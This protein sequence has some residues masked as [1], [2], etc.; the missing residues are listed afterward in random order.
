[1]FCDASNRTGAAVAR[2]AV[3]F[4]RYRPGAADDG[5]QVGLAWPMD[6][7]VDNNSCEMVAIIES[8]VVAKRELETVATSYG[9]QYHPLSAVVTIFSDSRCCLDDIL[10]PDPTRQNLRHR[11]LPH[12]RAKEKLL[13]ELKQTAG[14]FVTVE[15]TWV[16]GHCLAPN[17]AADVLAKRARLTNE[18][19]SQQGGALGPNPFGSVFDEPEV[20]DLF[21]A[22]QS[23]IQAR[24]VM[25]ATPRIVPSSNRVSRP[26]SSVKKRR[27]DLKSLVEEPEQDR[28]EREWAKQAEEQLLREADEAYE[29]L[30]FEREKE[31]VAEREEEREEEKRRDEEKRE[32]ENR[33]EKE[34][35]Q[36]AQEQLIRETDEAYERY[37]SEKEE[38]DTQELGG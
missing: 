22:K 13:V 26:S 29:R 3:V 36:Q 1:M 16:P 34:W 17:D 31:K 9:S 4:N 8:L 19:V 24:Q 11:L 23:E 30:L 14:I 28:Q 10:D 20:K 37:L 33:Q 32:E 35:A 7:G 2:Y 21:L 38:G 5:E 27:R 25:P 15:Y 18:A 12:I 6:P